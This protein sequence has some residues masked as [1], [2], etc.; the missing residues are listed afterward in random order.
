MLADVSDRIGWLGLPGTQ[1][2]TGVR[3]AGIGTAFWGRP[4]HGVRLTDDGEFVRGRKGSA[5]GWSSLPRTV[6]ERVSNMD[7]LSILSTSRPSSS[8]P[9]AS[10]RASS[11]PSLF[12]LGEE[13]DAD[14]LPHDFE[15]PP[16]MKRGTTDSSL[17]SSASS[18]G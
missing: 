12:D 11:S 16:A 5:E 3:E 2:R 6:L 9:A 10:P 13:E 1:R 18:R 17:R 14:E 8:R 7:T 15:P 4:R